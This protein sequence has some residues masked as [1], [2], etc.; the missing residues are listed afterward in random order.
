LIVTKLLLTVLATI[1]LLVRTQ[2]IGQVAGNGC[3]DSLAAGDLRQLRF[4]LI[5]DACADSF[6]LL[7]TT[8]IS[9]YKPGG[10]TS[11][12]LQKQ[13]Q[14]T[15]GWRSNAAQQGSLWGRYVL[16]GIIGVVRI[17]LLLHLAGLGLHAH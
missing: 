2:P 12:G 11:Y 8:M 5:G 3:T 16:F 15:P 1:I 13:E 10:M 6:V 9:I 7:V 14:M 17:L 4:Q